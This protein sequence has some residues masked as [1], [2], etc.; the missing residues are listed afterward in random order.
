MITHFGRISLLRSPRSDAQAAPFFWGALEW[1]GKC[2]Y[3]AC[4]EVGRLV[5]FVDSSSS[6]STWRS[7][8]TFER[9]R[10]IAAGRALSRQSADTRRESPDDQPKEKPVRVHSGASWCNH[11]P[12]LLVCF[13]LFTRIGLVDS[14]FFTYRRG[15]CRGV[16][17]ESERERYGCN[18]QEVK[19]CA[20]L[21]CW[22]WCVSPAPSTGRCYWQPPAGGIAPLCR[23]PCS[24][25][26]IDM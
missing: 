11:V 19:G 26:G 24:E 17:I 6:P 13:L 16:E 3:S 14:F 12:F 8:L 5:C 22:P 20:T 21:A 4:R 1:C 10:P 7:H 18:E 25:Q 2:G 15:V 23:L 9:A